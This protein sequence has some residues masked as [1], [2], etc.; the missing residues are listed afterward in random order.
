M[1]IPLHAQHP[2][3]AI[4]LMNYVYQPKIAAQLADFIWYVS[5]VPSAK[6]VVLNDI[7]DP[8]VANSPLVFPSPADLAKSHKYKVFK[9]SSEEDE[10]NSIFQPIYSS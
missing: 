2:V 10:W 6:D 1:C 3:D 5:P 4:M 7:K 8:T 9:D